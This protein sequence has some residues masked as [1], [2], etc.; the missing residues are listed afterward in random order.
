MNLRQFARGQECELMFV[1]CNGGT[2]TTVTAHLPYGDKGM[3]I[4]APDWW[5][6]HACFACHNKLDGRSK[7]APV[8][9]EHW[10]EDIMRALFRT[11]QKRIAAGLIK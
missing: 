11:T 2:E 5:S 6:V 4:K 8:D 7:R 9:V 1:D 3:G 10:H